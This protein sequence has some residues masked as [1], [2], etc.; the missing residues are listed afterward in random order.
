MRAFEGVN[1]P[2]I[3]RA[4]LMEVNPNEEI[5]TER[6]IAFIDVELEEGGS[7]LEVAKVIS[8]S[9]GRHIYLTTSYMAEDVQI[10]NFVRGVLGKEAPV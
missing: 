8:R 1:I 9:G 10:P 5:I 2:I 6:C 7:G 4:S 3:S